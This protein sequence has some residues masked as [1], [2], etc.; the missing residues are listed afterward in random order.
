MSVDLSFLLNVF[1]LLRLLTL[2]S[3]LLI[4]VHNIQNRESTR[5]LAV[6]EKTENEH[7]Q[8]PSGSFSPIVFLVFCFSKFLFLCRFRTYRAYIT[9]EQTMLESLSLVIYPFSS[10]V[11]SFSQTLWSIMKQI[12]FYL[13]RR[14]KKKQLKISY[15]LKGMEINHLR[16]HLRS[17]RQQGNDWKE[18][19]SW[20][21][22]F[23]G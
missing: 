7:I 2:I 3:F 1:P 16:I 14:R 10:H 15:F 19:R 13:I 23:C 9:H 11:A 17:W 6:L 12:I 5:C 8:S 18:F 4:F 20:K 22:S 21:N